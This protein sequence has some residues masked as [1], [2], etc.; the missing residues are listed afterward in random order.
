[1]VI[2]VDHMPSGASSEGVGPAMTADVGGGWSLEQADVRR[3]FEENVQP[4]WITAAL[5]IVD[6][7]R[8]ALRQYEYSRDEF[9]AM[10]P[11]DIDANEGPA[12]KVLLAI[13]AVGR[14]AGVD[15]VVARHRK[16]DGAFIDVELTSFAV[17]F[18][19]KPETYRARVM[20]KLGLTS[21]S[22]L[23]RFALESGV[24]APGKPA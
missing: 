1:L 13:N 7:N 14:G 15:P 9:L 5:G 18:A 21:R 4:M 3:V 6:V 23:V 22:D 19:G 2:D 24:L 16:K 10:P 20:D 17:T 12:G 11:A 8:A